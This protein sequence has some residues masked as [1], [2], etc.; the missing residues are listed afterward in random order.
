VWTALPLRALAVVV[1]AAGLFPLANYLTAGRAV[2]WWSLAVQEWLS[3]GSVVMAVAVLAALLLAGRVDAVLLRARVLILRPSPRDFA[4]VAAALLFLVAA[5][6]A[7]YCFSGKPFTSDEMAQQWHAR[8]LLSGRFAAVAEPQPAFF[9]TAPVWDRGGLWYSQYPVGGPLLIAVG[10][11]FGAP[12]AV[13]PLLLAVAGWQLYRFLGLTG[14]ELTARVTTLLFALSPMVLIMGASQMN[15]VPALAFTMVALHALVRWDRAAEP[16]DQRRCAGIIGLALGVV[17]AV[18]PL[19]AVLVAVCIGTLQMWRAF[20]DRGRWS[21]LMVQAI[22]VAVPVA[23]LLLANARTTGHP[24]V[25]GYDA[26]NGAEHGLG[27]HLDPNGEMHTP[28]RGLALASGY[29]LKLDRYLF[30]WPIPPLLFVIGGLWAIRTPSRWDVLLALLAAAFLAGYGA[31]WFDGFFSGPRF[32]FTAIP[33]FVY[34]TA[35]GATALARVPAARARRALLLVVP[36]CLLVAWV[37]PDGVSSARGRIALYRDQ[38]TKLKTDIDAQV[39]RA[40]LTNALVFV[41]EGWRG[42]LLARLRSLGASQFRAERLVNTLDACAL[43]D[44]LAAADRLPAPASRLDRVV[45]Q[46]RARGSARL[47]Q[48]LSA[49]QAVAVV[50][51]TIPSQAC[52]AEFQADSGGTIPYPPFLA[53]HSVDREGRIAGKVIFARDLGADNE[54]LRERFGARTWYRYRPARDLA[55]TTN[56]FAPYESTRER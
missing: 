34:F 20:S 55:D 21:S 54:R 10:M 38:R 44:A 53:R 49:D 28:A 5:G 47:V 8:I 29:L 14:D 24:L 30:E 31:Y 11:L 56:V 51:G 52:I 12:W 13:N 6:L 45:E 19:D 43:G 22:A 33:A 37:G 23:L 16:R 4:A 1:A 15:H 50:P 39:E 17:A 7:W 9:N 25:F 42:R 3:R 2:P 27:F 48:G 35:R 36:A 41:N 18:R 32:L 26:L 40:G 46:A